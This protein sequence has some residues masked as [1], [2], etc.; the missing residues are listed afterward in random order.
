MQQPKNRASYYYQLT[1]QNK[2]QTNTDTRGSISN[3]IVLSNSTR[4][5]TSTFSIYKTTNCRICTRGSGNIHNT[6]KLNIESFHTMRGLGVVYFHSSA[7]CFVH[8]LASDTDK[9]E[10][11]S[12][13][14]SPPLQHSFINSVY[15]TITVVSSTHLSSILT[16]NHSQAV[17]K[18]GTRDS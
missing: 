14:L 11:Q 8:P 9:K 16:I 3:D 1:L 5:C 18:G 4:R 12:L 6:L 17:K 15:T 7:V 2:N 10:K 13:H